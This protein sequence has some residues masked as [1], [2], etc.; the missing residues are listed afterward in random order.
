LFCYERGGTL[1][2]VYKEAPGFPLATMNPRS[3]TA[4]EML[5]QEK[6]NAVDIAK[7]D[8]NEA[9]DVVNHMRIKRSGRCKAP[10]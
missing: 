9:V 10:Y 3:F 6:H 4:V 8:T 7:R 5:E 1:P 2:G